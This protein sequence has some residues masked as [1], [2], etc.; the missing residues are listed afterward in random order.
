MKQIYITM[1][2]V[3][4]FMM[5]GIDSLKAQ[6]GNVEI[7]TTYTPEVASANKLLAP[8]RIADD[9]TIDPD[10][11][12]NVKTSLWQIDLNSHQF[13]PA[14]ASYWDYSGYKQFY[15]KADAGY[16]LASDLC[17]RY[18]M[19]TPKLGYLG[20]GVDHA[21]DFASRNDRSIAESF[22]MQNRVLLNGGIFAGSRM[23]EASLVYDN[24]IYNGYS[25]VDPER[26]LFHDATLA[27]R[28]GDDFI[29]L[30]KLNFAIE[31]DGGLWAHRLPQFENM[32]SEYR[33]S[34]SVKLVREFSD[35]LINVDLDFGMWQSTKQLG[36]GDIRFGGSVGYARRFGFVSVEAGLGYLY[37][38][39]KMRDR[40]S[41]FILPRAKVMFDL[42]KASF[43]P[44]VEL[45]S[46]V[47]HN[48]VASLYALNPYIDSES[49]VSSLSTM[50]N[51]LNYNL[52]LG[53]TG[54]IFESRFTYH[55]YVGADFI[56][57]QLFWYISRPG[58][59]GVDAYNNNRIFMGVG[60]KYLPI[61]GL[62]LGLD[63][64]YHF[65]NHKSPY[66]QSEP[67]MCGAVNIRYTLRD[68]SFYVGGKLL[69]SRSWT[70]V[71][72]QMPN[73]AMPTTFDLGAGVGYCINNRVEVFAKG[74]NLLN[75]KIYDYAHYYQPGAGVKVGVK[76]DF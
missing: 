69:G 44:Y 53:F 49:V 33:A 63:F 36:Y 74:Q 61:A 1:S 14:R 72:E 47:S 6:Q 40:A 21:G 70:S 57:D 29:N 10:I 56:R 2:V 31:L 5:C 37:D 9:P 68:W 62:E 38:R 43:V 39:V 13:K 58:E 52:S 60:A 7:V 32:Q 73:F 3:A 50:P 24:D 59:F 34:A 28:F 64:S 22:N 19:Q 30:E 75:S 17:F 35:N 12:Y 23:F 71:D 48:D 20:V 18:A 66:A 46:G 8:T 67:Q 45:S 41:H 54:T 55:A 4:L 65:D 16:P 42:E 26:R 51:T 15:V 27:L 25:M 76:V 11:E